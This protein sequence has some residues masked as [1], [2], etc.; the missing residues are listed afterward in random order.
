[1]KRARNVGFSLMEVILAIG[2]L[3]LAILALLGLF[4]PTMTS[5]KNVIDRNEATGIMTKVNAFLQT[6]DPNAGAGGRINVNFGN[7]VNWAN[8]GHVLYAWNSQEIDA[9][10]G[11][12]G[13]NQLQIAADTN[14]L[15]TDFRDGKIESSVF[16]IVLS[17]ARFGNFNYPYGNAN[18]EGY[19]PMTVSIYVVD[20]ERVA[21]GQVTAVVDQNG[22]NE[23]ASNGISEASLLISYTTAKVR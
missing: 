6:N 13:P 1:M 16:I 21:N 7:V 23:D 3:S 12:L 2:V 15:S 4:A 11:A 22:L 8:A 20:T 5:V 14:L 17:R 18:T 10:T 19:V 9:G